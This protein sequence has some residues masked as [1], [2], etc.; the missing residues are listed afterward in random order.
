MQQQH[1][2]PEP[3]SEYANHKADGES[4]PRQHRGV[5]MAGGRRRGHGWWPWVGRPLVRRMRSAVCRGCA[6]GSTSRTCRRR[7]STRRSTSQWITRTAHRPGRSSP[8]LSC[9][10][11][12]TTLGEVV[13]DLLGGGGHWLYG[14]TRA[15]IAAELARLAKRGR[16]GRGGA[17][18]LSHAVGLPHLLACPRWSSRRA[19]PR[20]WRNTA[21]P[22]SST[23][24]PALASHH[25][26]KLTVATVQRYLNARRAAGDSVSQAGDDEGSCSAPRSAAPCARSS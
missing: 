23:Y 8:D 25:L 1:H 16:L 6:G 5:D 13:E 11:L 19:G 14:R 22:S 3:R 20:P 9:I 17:H 7:D 24:A 15:E 26:D 10:G 21:P 4:R 12:V 18:P 2:T